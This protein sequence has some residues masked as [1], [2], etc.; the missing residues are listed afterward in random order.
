MCASVRRSS[1]PAHENTSM[2]MPAT[3]RRLFSAVDALE[4]A[5]PDGFVIGR[6]LEEGDRQDLHW[7]CD[8]TSEA[9][10]CDWFGRNATRQL[11]RR[12][13]A[14]WSLVLSLPNPDVPVAADDP[15]WPL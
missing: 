11:S 3:T 7:L 2:R 9:V 14:F 13:R 10:L 5:S 6:L 15:L 4:S 12:S 8:E 1:G